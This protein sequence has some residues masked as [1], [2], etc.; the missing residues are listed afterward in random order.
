MM[1]ETALELSKEENSQEIWKVQVI[2]RPHPSAAHSLG[3]SYLAASKTAICT[4]QVQHLGLKNV[5]PELA[6]TI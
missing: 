6:S 4:L 3:D 5:W 2:F 1:K